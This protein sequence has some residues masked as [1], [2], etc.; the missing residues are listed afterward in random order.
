[1]KKSLVESLH[2]SKAGRTFYK[3]HI[4]QVLDTALDKKSI[5]NPGSIRMMP[6]VVGASGDEMDS[7]AASEL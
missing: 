3:K 1:M 7:L 4:E 6:P 5:S 2:K